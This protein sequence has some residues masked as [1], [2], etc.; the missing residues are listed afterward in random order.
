VT[1][2]I[3]LYLDDLR[4]CP[5]GFVL[6]RN[7]EEFMLLLEHESVGV[8]SLDHDL[9]W[10]EPNGLEVAR[11]MIEQKRYP[12]E[13]YLHS[14]NPLGRASM[15]QLLYNHKPEGTK[16]YMTPMPE[17]LLFRICRDSR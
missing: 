10:N 4:A 3:H 5:K 8:A 1:G 12:Q 15:Y 7:A 9:G 11:R 13:I 17:E 14:S 6:A 2:L 16:L